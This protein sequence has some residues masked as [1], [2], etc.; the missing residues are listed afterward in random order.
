[1]WFA[2]VGKRT[3]HGTTARTRSP[4]GE[5]VS[6]EEE[7]LVSVEA[8]RVDQLGAHRRVVVALDPALVGDLPAA[9]GVERRL[10]ELR[11][12]RSVAEILE[13]AEL[14]EHVDLR[15]AD[16]LRC[17]PCVA[18]EVG[19]ALREPA[20]ARSTGDLLV[21]LHLG[22]VPVDVH[23]LAALAGELD[24]QLDRE[25]VGRGEPE[26]VLTGDVAAGQLVELPHAAVDRLAE[27]LLLRANDALD[28]VGV[29]DDLRVPGADLLDDDA[30]QLVDGGQPDPARLDDRAADQP[31]EHV[32]A[33]LVRRR[34]PLGDEECHP[35]AVVGEDPMGLRRLRRGAVVDA[36]LLLDPVHD[37]PEAVRVEDRGGL[38]DEHRAPLEPHA[39]VD[40]LLR[41]RRHG[42]VCGEVELHEDEVPELD[43]AVTAIAVR[44]AVRLAAAVLGATVVVELR[45]GAARAGLAGGAP[46]V[47]GAR[48]RHDA[49]ARKALPQPGGDGDLVL[50]DAERRVTRE[51]ARPEPVGVELQMLGDE[52]PRQV[53]G[54]VLEV[55]AEREVA[56]HLEHRRVARGETDLVEVGVL[57]A[58]AQALLDGREPRR[59]RLLRTG[60]VR[61]QRLH[62]GGDEQR[63]RI[64][65]RRDQRER[66]EPQM[67]SLLEEGEETLAEL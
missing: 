28:L 26:R 52:L 14:R 53:D 49:L 30:W 67:V 39:R 19:R 44:P 8:E 40:V 13:R 56:E 20:L 29:L 17:E 10:A 64:L 47:L 9:G 5:S 55:V 36:G 6:A 1:M 62:P 37:Q 38:L 18:R 33:P 50:A 12:E 63:G 31:A 60:E 32:P 41:E 4:L 25:A 11:E 35:P 27:A 22:P 7:R 24:G 51:H 21:A 61:L 65:R 59:G 57:P 3:L 45:A 54:A 23:L 34:D 42:A 15:V 66:R 48:E 2:M 43:V 58:R 46:E 16:E